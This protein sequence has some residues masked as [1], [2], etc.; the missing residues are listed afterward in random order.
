MLFDYNKT[1]KKGFCVEN[2]KIPTS[3]LS[4][5]F[6]FH[7]FTLM[8]VMPVKAGAEMKRPTAKLA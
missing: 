6:V 5:R 1:M 4:D 7:V 2:F 3:N 8:T